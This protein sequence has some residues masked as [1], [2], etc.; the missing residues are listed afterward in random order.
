MQK[1]FKG[2]ENLKVIQESIKL[3]GHHVSQKTDLWAVINQHMGIGYHASS[4]NA[5]ECRI[6]V[7]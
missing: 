5:H 1:H 3:L 6:L 4:M 2:P 7:H